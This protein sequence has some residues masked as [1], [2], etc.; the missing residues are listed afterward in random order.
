MEHGPEP[1]SESHAWHQ[2]Q[3]A[4]SP[5]ALCFHL[6]AAGKSGF[7]ARQNNFLCAAKPRTYGN[8]VQ[9][10]IL[11]VSISFYLY[12]MIFRVRMSIPIHSMSVTS[13]YPHPILLPRISGRYLRHLLWSRSSVFLT[14]KYL[15]FLKRLYCPTGCNVWMHSFFVLLSPP[16]LKIIS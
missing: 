12:E 4:K 2:A 7:P 6:K 9:Q 16:R 8:C 1:S 11:H 14:P 15:H 3:P 13:T 10:H 5:W